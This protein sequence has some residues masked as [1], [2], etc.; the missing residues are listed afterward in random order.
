MADFNEEYSD[1][2]D[3][4]GLVG[5]LPAS[6][7]QRTVPDEG[8]FTGPEVGDPLPGFKLR[9]ATGA[10]MNLHA[11]RNGSKAAVV[12]YRSAVW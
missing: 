11:D 12:F 2:V 8:F 3:E 7:G 9:T 5:P 6:D 4:F 1:Y 10:K